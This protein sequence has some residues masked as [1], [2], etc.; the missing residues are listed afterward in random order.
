[1]KNLFRELIPEIDLIVGKELAINNIK[2]R[3][4]PL[5]NESKPE[6]YNVDNKIDLKKTMELNHYVKSYLER[7]INL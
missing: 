7:L 6:W 3:I 4:W 5:S 2:K 1:M